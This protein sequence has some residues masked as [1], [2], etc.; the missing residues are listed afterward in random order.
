[1]TPDDARRTQ[2]ANIPWDPLD[3][4]QTR[5][6]LIHTL[7]Q[8]INVEFGCARTFNLHLVQV[9]VEGRDRWSTNTS[10]SLAIHLVGMGCNLH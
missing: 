8:I 9:N 1:M 10:P 7:T 3:E 4:G 2:S 6:I 5:A